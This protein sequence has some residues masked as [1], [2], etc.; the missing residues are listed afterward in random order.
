MKYNLLFGL[1]TATL[2]VSK[3]CAETYDYVRPLP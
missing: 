3:A 2:A 1:C